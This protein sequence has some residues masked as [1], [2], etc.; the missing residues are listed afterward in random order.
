MNLSKVFKALSIVI[1]GLGAWQILA[2][3]ITL[4]REGSLASGAGNAEKGFAVLSFIFLLPMIL[5]G[6]ICLMCGIAGLKSDHDRCKKCSNILAVL[7]VLDLIAGIVQ[8][9]VSFL[10]VLTLIVCVVYC[11]FAHTL[12]Y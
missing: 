9:D 8:K 6:I 11:Y 2:V 12:R 3:I 1:I 7:A 4:M 10:S 5:L